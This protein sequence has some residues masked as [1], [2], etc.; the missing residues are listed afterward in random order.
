[1]SNFWDTANN[2]KIVNKWHRIISMDN[3][4]MLETSQRPQVNK[5]LMAPQYLILDKIHILE[6]ELVS[7]VQISNV[8]IAAQTMLEI[9]QV[10]SYLL[11]VKTSKIRVIKFDLII[12]KSI[13]RIKI[14]LKVKWLLPQA[15]KF[16]SKLL[17][18]VETILILMEILEFK[19]NKIFWKIKNY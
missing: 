8:L 9:I 1:M 5:N 2:R 16:Q 6:V 17:N 14:N 10:T 4:Q 19:D 15:I 13:L 7:E 11:E 3:K 18:M 12:S